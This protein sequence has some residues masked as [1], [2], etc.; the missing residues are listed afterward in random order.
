MPIQNIFLIAVIVTILGACNSNSS[1]LDDFR[2]RQDSLSMP[3][4]EPIL[5]QPENTELEVAPKKIPAE[6]P[7]WADKTIEKVTK[8][9][10]MANTTGKST[11]EYSTNYTERDGKPYISVE[12]GTQDEDK[13][14]VEKWLYIDTLTKKVYEHDMVN[15]KLVE[16][17]D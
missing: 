14:T 11:F 6:H 16:V 12:I 9:L 17:K 2:N 7:A 4:D 13:F 1:Q 8:K 5:E 3:S 15:D 10:F